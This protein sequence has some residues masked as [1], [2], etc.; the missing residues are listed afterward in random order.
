MVHLLTFREHPMPYDPRV[1]LAEI[2]TVGD[3]VEAFSDE[4]RCR[5]FLEAMV[6]PRGRI[7]PSCVRIPTIAAIDSD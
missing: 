5:W 3:M 4:D 6:W 1:S 2:A 7:C